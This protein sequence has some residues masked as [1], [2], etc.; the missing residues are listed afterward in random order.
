[1]CNGLVTPAPKSSLL[2]IKLSLSVQSGG[3][4]RWGQISQPYHSYYLK[5]AVSNEHEAHISCVIYCAYILCLTV[6]MLK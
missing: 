3:R 6:A 4:E 1:M 5:H 2:T